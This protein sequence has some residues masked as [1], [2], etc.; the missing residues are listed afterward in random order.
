MGRF[1]CCFRMRRLNCSRFWLAKLN[2]NIKSKL[3]MKETAE[4]ILQM[5]SA[6]SQFFEQT[7]E[8]CYL[9]EEEMCNLIC[10]DCF[11]NS[12]WEG[13]V[14]TRYDRLLYGWISVQK[15]FIRTLESNEIDILQKCL[16]SYHSL[17]RLDALELSTRLMN[18]KLVNFHSD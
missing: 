11:W 17:L 14:W 15:F 1:N 16:T 4:V 10:I 12:E 2:I 5:I 7:S 13:M 3:I 9:T 8:V 6:E 18:K